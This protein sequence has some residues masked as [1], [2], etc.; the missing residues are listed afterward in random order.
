MEKPTHM[1]QSDYLTKP[2]VEKLRLTNPKGLNRF[3]E[4][5]EEPRL[6]VLYGR[7]C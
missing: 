6:N 3:I 2:T 7:V 1:P 5:D 4:K